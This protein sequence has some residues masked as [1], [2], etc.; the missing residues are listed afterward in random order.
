MTDPLG[1]VTITAREV[2][3][4]VMKVAASVDR[5]VNQGDGHGEDIRDHETRL[6]ALEAGRWPLPAASL[7]IGLAALGVALLP[8]LTK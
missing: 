5:L 6:R 7:L 3:D 8:I 4:A 2:Y 1:P